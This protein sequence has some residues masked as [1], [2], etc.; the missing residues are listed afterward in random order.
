MTLEQW[1]YIGEIIAAIAVIASLIYIGSELRQNTEALQAQARFNLISQRASFADLLMQD[2]ELLDIL[3]RSQAKEELS[4][5]E[6]IAVYVHAIRT[7]EMWEWQHSEYQAG[8]LPAERLP[9]RAWRSIFHEKR[10]PNAVRE[11][12]ET[13]KDVLS[14]KFV[15]FMEESIAG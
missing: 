14:P 2:R 11:V 9:L 12:W 10:I 8:T 6:E 7:L 15:K 13:R 4:R 5:A 1:A 3:A